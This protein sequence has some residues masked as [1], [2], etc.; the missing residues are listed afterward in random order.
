M[1]LSIKKCVYKAKHRMEFKVSLLVS[2]LA[3]ILTAQKTSQTTPTTTPSSTTTTLSTA[4]ASAPTTTTAPK[5][6]D[7]IDYMV[8]PPGQREVAGVEMYFRD[9]PSLSS[10]PVFNVYLGDAFYMYIR[11]TGIDCSPNKV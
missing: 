5:T 8:L 4:T 6:N 9:G 10:A 2:C 7:T 11:Y 3:I 1:R